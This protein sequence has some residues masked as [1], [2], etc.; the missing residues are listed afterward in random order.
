MFA[1]P[2]RA[3]HD[4]ASFGFVFMP[5]GHAKIFNVKQ[6]AASALA[7]RLRRPNSASIYRV[8][9][10]RVHTNAAAHQAAIL[11]TLGTPSAA[12]AVA[13][14]WPCGGCFRRMRPVVLVPSLGEK[15]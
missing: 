5:I 1:C 4:Q 6:V 13:E 2:A 3:H 8:D 15:P 10:V 12:A 9:L 11:R 7:R 14:V